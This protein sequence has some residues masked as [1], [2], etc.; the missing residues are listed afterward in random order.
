MVVRGARARAAEVVEEL[1]RHACPARR[2]VTQGYFPSRLEILGVSAPAIRSVL[3]PLA[4]SLDGAP[5]RDVLALARALLAT[6]VHEARQVAYE[7]LGGRRDVVMGLDAATLEAVGTGNDNWAS[8]DTFSAYVAGPAW[9]LGALRDADVL[10]W[11]R[12]SDRW[13]RRTA[14]VSTVAL[15]LRSR[16]GMGDVPR[17]LRICHVLAGDAAPMVAKG[18]SWALRA[19]VP[20]DAAAV[21]RFLEDG[22]ERLPALVRREVG[23]KLATGLKSGR[24]SGRR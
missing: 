16:G 9:R 22:R 5:P 18:L 1:R 2:E 14:R 15:N 21:R 17:T 24:P 8:V 12:S 4:R 20:V 10:G 6:R 3:R 7:L 11:S 13:W 23:N 19:L